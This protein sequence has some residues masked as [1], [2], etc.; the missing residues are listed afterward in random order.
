MKKDGLNELPLLKDC[1]SFLYVEMAIIEQDE[2]SIC[3]K[4][5]RNKYR[6]PITQFAS[7]LVGPGVS[8][9][10]EAMKN[11][12]NAG[13]IVIW[14]KRNGDGFYVAGKGRN[15]NTQNLIMQ[16]KAFSDPKIHH[17]VARNMYKLRFPD[18]NMDKFSIKQM[19]GA[20]GKRIQKRYAELAQK[21]NIAWDGRNYKKDD[22]ENQDNVNKI[23][24]MSNA[25]LHD[26]VYSFLLILG[27]SPD[28]GFIHT[29]NTAS[30]VYDISDL[31]KSEITI[32][33]AFEL[34]SNS[35]SKRL[36]ILV[37]EEMHKYIND[38]QLLKR[39]PKDMELIFKETGVDVFIPNE[40]SLW[41]PDG[42]E[43]AMENKALI[44]E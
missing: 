38:F 7:L 16:A 24:S 27:F 41:T 43:K 22:W 12:A 11:I 4:Q 34:A 29:G 44:A 36:D 23:L 39:F 32:P 33:L 42:F 26:I 13:T 1:I 2:F 25:I 15:N 40:F 19:Q 30:F 18:K 31:Y 14:C 28:L 5:G 9:T 8:I 37:R 3:I 6:V 21:Y 35:N 17:K 20:E 10:H